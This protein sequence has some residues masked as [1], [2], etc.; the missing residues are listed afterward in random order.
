MQYFMII[1]GQQRGPFQ[2]DMLVMQG[3]RPD[4]YVWREGMLNWAP[5]STMPELADLLIE[6]SAFGSYA[7]PEEPAPPYNANGNAQGGFRSSAYGQQPYGQQPYGQQP[8]G[9]QPYNQQPYGPPAAHTNWFPWAI[10]AMVLGIL[11]SLIGLIFGIIATVKAKKANDLY[12]QGMNAEASSV[13][14]T[15]MTMTILAFV[16][17]VI[18]IGSSIW[19]LSSGVLQSLS[20]LS[21][22]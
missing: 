22:I 12:N 4:T 11:S 16:F 9:Q 21:L 2:R 3:L 17:E 19:L 13:N 20:P 18:G 8:Y 1:D 5:A 15:A 10:V 14:S 6:E 7:R